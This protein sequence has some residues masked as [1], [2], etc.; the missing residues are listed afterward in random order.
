MSARPS[1]S[2]SHGECLRCVRA[3]APRRHRHVPREETRGGTAPASSS[4]GWTTISGCGRWW[5]TTCAMPSCATSWKLHYQP[6]VSADGTRLAAS[7]R[8]CAGGIPSTPHPADRVHQHRRRA[9]PHHPAWRMGDPRACLDAVNW[10]DVTVACNVSAVQ[11]RQQDFV[12]SVENALADTKFDPSRLELELT[13]SVVVAD[14]DQ[15][16]DS[17]MDLRAM[18]VKLALDDFGTGLLEPD[19][20]PTLRLRQDQA[21]QVIPRQSGGHRRK[22]DPRALGRAS[23]ACAR[24]DRDGGGRRDA[25]AAALPAGRR[26]PP[27]QGYLFA[28]PMTAQQIDELVKK[29]HPFDEAA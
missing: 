25:R 26:L 20:S 13:E 12:R 18:G 11:F 7:R 14:A 3:D 19:L 9:R 17:I 6:Q 28:K 2:R 24:P 21:R 23:R 16:E 5:R 27:L 8:W 4:S 15:A 22:R 1:A 29:S 10:G